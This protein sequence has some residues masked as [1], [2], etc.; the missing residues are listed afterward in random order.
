V[1]LRPLETRLLISADGR[2]YY[3][4]EPRKVHAQWWLHSAILLGLEESY[5]PMGPGYSVTPAV[6]STMGALEVLAL[7]RRLYGDETYEDA[8][9]S[10]FGVKLGWS[11][12]TLYRLALDHTEIFHVYHTVQKPLTPLHCYDVWY[13]AQLPWKAHD[14][15]RS[16]CLFSVVQSTV[17]G[18]QPITLRNMYLHAVRSKAVLDVKRDGY[19]SGSYRGEL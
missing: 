18:L 17:S 11:E 10:S 15:L 8:W 19:G 9:L 16:G 6:M 1:L 13:T 3:E 4:A 14:A 12:Y 5:D 2:G 7:L